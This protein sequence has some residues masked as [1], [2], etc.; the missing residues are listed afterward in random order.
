MPFYLAISLRTILISFIPILTTLSFINFSAHNDKPSGPINS[1][2][3]IDSIFP[4]IKLTSG[5]KQHWFGYYDKLQVDPSGRYILGC[6]VDHFFRSPTPRDTLRIGVID[7]QNDNEWRELGISTA[8]GWQQGCMLQWVPGSDSEIIWNDQQDGKFVSHILNLKTGQKRTLPKPIYTLSNDGT[9]GLGTEFNRI[10]NLRPGYGYSGIEDPYEEF[11]APEE[12]GIYKLDLK[13][14]KDEFIVSIAEMAA[15]DN[16]GENLKDH[17]HY[18]NHLLIS[19][20]DQRFILLHRWRKEIEEDG[21]KKRSGFITRMITANI[22]GSDK[23]I[24]DPSGFTSHFIWRDPVN[25]CMWTQPV[26]GI[27]G[28]YIFKDKT[29]E[30]TAVGKGIMTLNGHN[31]YVAKTNKDWILNDTYPQGIGRLQELYL[32]HVPTQRKVV[33]GRFHE[34]I[35][36][37][38]EWRCDLH[39]RYSQDGK[40]VIFDS[41]HEED[42]RQMYMIDISEIVG[43]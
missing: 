11:R 35:E 14:G 33:L 27:P 32:Y 39:P 25:I 21:V 36:Y 1:N 2:P 29:T 13:T 12:I 37:S 41:T 20:D 19:P 24:L 18:F 22:D 26:N 38:G 23:Y 34:P 6:E 3:A 30:I 7:L 15:I 42:G 8:W 16:L 10:Q 31:T 5:D 43:T 40:F 17:W 28:F 9:F 4:V